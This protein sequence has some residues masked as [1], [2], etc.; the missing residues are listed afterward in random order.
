MMRG[1][2]TIAHS[3]DIHQS[4]ADEVLLSLAQIGGKIRGSCK[5]LQ[6]FCVATRNFKTWEVRSKHVIASSETPS[7]R[8]LRPRLNQGKGSNRPASRPQ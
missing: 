7:A 5:S 6:R 3:R 2:Q 4:S 8:K 1:A